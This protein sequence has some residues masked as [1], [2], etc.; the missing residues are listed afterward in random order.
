MTL[1]MLPRQ[2]EAMPCSL[3]TRAKQSMM[4][5]YRGI[6]PLLILGLLSC[7][8]SSSLTRSMGATT[9]LLIAP[10]TPPAARSFRNALPLSLAFFASS[11]AL[12]S[13][14]CA[15]FFALSIALSSSGAASALQR[16][17]RE[18]TA[19]SAPVRLPMRIASDTVSAMTC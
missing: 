7:V 8:C 6:S 15:A 17:P 12:S 13:A 3:L 14:S 16:A 10:A 2:K 9:V 1:A 11:A 18:S 5:L 4:P 19:A